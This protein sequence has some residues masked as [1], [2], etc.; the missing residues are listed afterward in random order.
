MLGEVGVG[1][2]LGWSGGWRGYW[3]LREVNRRWMS[4]LQFVSE[5]FPASFFFVSEIRTNFHAQFVK[6]SI[7]IENV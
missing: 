2:G 5:A 7:I 1:G 6:S 4:T 3:R